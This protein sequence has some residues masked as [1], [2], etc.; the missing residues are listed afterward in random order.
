MLFS[1]MRAATRKSHQ[2]PE[3]ADFMLDLYE[4]YKPLMRASIKKIFSDSQE[5][6]DLVHDCVVKLIPMVPKLRTL[7]RCALTVYVVHTARNIAKNYLKRQELRNRHFAPV[8]MA[9]VDC[10]DAALSPEELALLSERAEEFHKKF[11]RLPE[12]VRDLLIDKYVL[13]M[14]DEE[15]SG[16]F[17]CKPASVRMKLTRA[18]RTACEQMKGEYFDEQT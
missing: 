5:N 17:S 10:T 14:S 1:A 7:D 16:F 6:E 13:D 3:D 12:P 4:Q 18:R 15:L 9:A 2:S 11:D 8:D